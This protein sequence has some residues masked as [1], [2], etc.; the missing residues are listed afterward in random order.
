MQA[1]R[2]T[3]RAV[4]CVGLSINSSSLSDT[5]WASYAS[6]LSACLKLPVVDPLRGGVAALAHALLAP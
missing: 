4:R 3:N 5:Q 6:D 1:A 2:L